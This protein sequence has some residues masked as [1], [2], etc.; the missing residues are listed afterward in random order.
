MKSIRSYSF[1][2]FQGIARSFHGNVA[3]GIM[4][5]GYMVDFAYQNLPEHGLYNVI[6]ETAKC[7]PDAV[8]LLTPCSIGNQRLKILDVGRF[9]L[10]FYEKRSGKGVRVFLDV[11]KL[12]RWPETKRWFL[13][14]RPKAEQD[15]SLLLSEIGSAGPNTLSVRAVAVANSFLGKKESG[16]VTICS[17]CGEAYHACDGAICPACT[18]GHLPYVAVEDLCAR[19]GRCA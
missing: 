9:A 17:C 11:E 4:I 19:K 15:L 1:E 2:E 5:G 18:D 14:L 7:L 3:P 6:C 10:T 16:P 12:E 8:Q 13:K